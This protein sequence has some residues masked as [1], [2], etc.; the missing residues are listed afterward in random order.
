MMM[1]NIVIFVLVLVTA[2][3]AVML[4]GIDRFS[5]MSGRAALSLLMCAIPAVLLAGFSIQA[6][7]TEKKNQLRNRSLE[8]NRYR[9][10]VSVALTAFILGGMTGYALDGLLRTVAQY[11]PGRSV[12]LDATVKEVHE[13]GGFKSG[14]KLSVGIAAREASLGIVCAVARFAPAIGPVDLKS[15]ESIRLQLRQTPLGVVAT[16]IRRVSNQR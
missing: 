2:R 9:W 14:C 5:V 7:I 8:R 10:I 3:L 11:L 13:S 6:M 15:G 16:R 12:E 1:T 4:V